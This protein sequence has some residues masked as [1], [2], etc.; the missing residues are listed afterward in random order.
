MMEALVPEL[1]ARRVALRRPS[2]EFAGRLTPILNAS[3]ELHR[4]FLG[5][6]KPSWTVVEVAERLRVA[7]EKFDAREEEVRYYVFDR[8]DLVG[9]VGV[10]LI[11]VRIPY[12]ELGYW[13][14]AEHSRRGYATD[15]VN[16]LR[17]TLQR[18]GARRVEVCC[19]GSNL[20]SHQVALNAGFMKEALLRAHRINPGGD[21]DDTVIFAAPPLG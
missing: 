12:V 5:W 14:G 2:E 21:V 10:F 3:Y 4:R 1:Q 20:A 18:A 15:A 17:H 9:C 8:D 13:T 7:R 11:N 19:S 6:A 16:L